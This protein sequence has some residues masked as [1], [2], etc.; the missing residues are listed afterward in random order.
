MWYRRQDQD[1]S[2]FE[3]SNY[4]LPE[5]ILSWMGLSIALIMLVAIGVW[6]RFPTTEMGEKLFDPVF[7]FL[8]VVGVFFVPF[9]LYEARWKIWEHSW[10]AEV[11][12]MQFIS[13]M[14]WI[15][16][17]LFLLV[18]AGLVSYVMII[19]WGNGGPDNNITWWQKMIF[20]GVHVLVYLSLASTIS[21][22]R[23]EMLL[24]Y[25]RDNVD[26]PIYTDISRLKNVVFEE[27]KKILN[28]EDKFDSLY[29]VHAVAQKQDN[30]PFFLK[31]K[32]SKS[33]KDSFSGKTRNSWVIV[34]SDRWG[35]IRRLGPPN[36]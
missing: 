14:Q 2:R 16:F 24:R 20:G 6:Y 15:T 28:D 32:L 27:T 9:L 12:E 33:Q 25:L 30:R 3:G 22:Y 35:H 5:I 29:E 17:F 23:F 13:P 1:K 8:A 19:I 11:Y 31:F 7:L 36:A 4:V 26:Q 10:R 18:F 21:Y 34:V